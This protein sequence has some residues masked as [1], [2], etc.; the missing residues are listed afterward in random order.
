MRERGYVN[1]K[2]SHDILRMNL[3]ISELNGLKKRFRL[4]IRNANKEI[5]GYKM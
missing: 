2:G 3:N 4:K 1:E 5:K